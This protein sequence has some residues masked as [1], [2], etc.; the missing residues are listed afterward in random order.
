MSH[1][2][3]SYLVVNVAVCKHGVEVL[4][5]LTGTAVVIVLQSLLDAAHVHRI[6]YDLMIILGIKDMLLIK[7]VT[8]QTIYKYFYPSETTLRVIT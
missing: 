8:F 7:P 6:L 2:S 5:A 3:S 1:P 4:H